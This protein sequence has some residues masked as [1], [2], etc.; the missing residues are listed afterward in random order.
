MSRIA[1]AGLQ[2]EA[3]NG[4]NTERMEAEIDAVLRRF[5][6]VEMVVAAELNAC[7]SR[8]SEAEPMP[9]P[10]EAHFS[11]IARRHGIWLVPGSMFES[12]GGKIYN[13]TP[14]IDP[15]GE[16]IAR[17]RKLF[18]WLPYEKDTSPGSDFVVFDVPGAGRFGLSTCYDMWFPETLR[19]LTW[20][21]AEVIL[22]PSLT[23]TIDRQAELA[24]VRAHA[25]AFQCYFFDVNLGPT[26]G[27]GQSC[28]AGPGGGVLHQ[29]GRGREIFP[30]KLDFGYVRDVRNTGWNNLSQPLKSFRDSPVRFPCYGDRY[31]SRAL[32]ALGPLA[33]PARRGERED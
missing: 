8:A 29:A 19:A 13:T 12:A 26:V 33:I 6:W 20:L 28:V 17:Y 16:V 31:G 7:G 18:P 25:A 5:P 14:V 27:C 30:L 1:I 4:D 15:E 9:G 10:R 2:L 22:H 23:S 3:V 21:G 24:M 32:D 11:R